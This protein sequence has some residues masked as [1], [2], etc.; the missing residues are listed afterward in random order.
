MTRRS[1]AQGSIY[2]RRKAGKPEP[3]WTISYRAGGR[4]V[5]ERAFADRAASEQLLANRL[6]ESAREEVGLL[7]PYRRHRAAPIAEHVEAFIA[8]VRSRNRTAK[9]VELLQVRVERA[10]AG[11]GAAT[12][13]QVDLARAEKVLADVLE[14][15]SPKTRDHYASSLRQFGAWLEDADRWPRNLF[16]RLRRVSRPS[17]ARVERMA[18][19]AEQVLALV[20]AAERRPR[21][22]LTRAGPRT[23]DRAVAEGRRRGTL[24]LFSAMTGLRSAECA[25]IRWCDLDLAGTAPRV[26]PRPETTKARRDE[27]LPLV[28]PLLGRLR[29]L[30]DE[31]ARAAG[32]PPR[33]TAPV[34]TVP[35]HIAARLRDDAEFAGIETKD[36]R[37]RRLDFHALRA[38]CATMLARAGVPV[39]VARRLMRHSSPAMT[40]RHYEKLADADLRAGADELA[41]AMAA[42]ASEAAVTATQPAATGSNARAT[43]TNSATEGGRKSV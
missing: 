42:A 28:E 30:R 40:A 36:D 29:E 38:T 14:Q 37:G 1:R 6:R 15:H 26:T 43:D 12:L 5:T 13:G 31:A 19:T 32:R 22:K 2:R 4:R 17:D 35:Q 23:R 3:C 41:K 10:L 8:G 24:Y 9:H 7:D 20:A 27:P 33:L 18:L 11:M 34:F 16:G 21:Q 39:Q 25:G